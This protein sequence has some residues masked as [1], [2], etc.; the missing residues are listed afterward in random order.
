MYWFA[1][2]NGSRDNPPPVDRA[3]L[4]RLF[5]GWHQPIAAILGATPLK[6]I[7]L[8]PIDELSRCPASLWRG[9][10]V[11]VG[12]AAHAMTPNLGQGANLALEDAATLVGLLAPYAAQAHPPQ[13]Q[14]PRALEAYQQR[15]SARVRAIWR[16]SRQI[17]TL[18]QW[19]HPA[20]VRI[21]DAV[22]S[23]LP[24]GPVNASSVTL[25]SW[26]PTLDR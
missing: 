25:Q 3:A 23:R 16:R 6:A 11:L 24:D 18:G 4:E 17:G 1:T 9:N 19:E 10:V 7:S 21:R 13:D 14:I 2:V 12:D 26:T 20:A 8:L 22:F 5:G 15:R